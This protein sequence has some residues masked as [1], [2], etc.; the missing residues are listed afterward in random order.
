[1]DG[2]VS[3]HLPNG[4]DASLPLV[5]DP[6]VVFATFTGATS[7]NWGATATYDKSGNFYGGGTSAAAGFPV[8]LGAFQT[9]HGGGTT[10][11]VPGDMAFIKFD[12]TGATKIWA[13]YLGGNGLDQPH[14]MIVDSADNLI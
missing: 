2:V 5:I 10:L 8:S 7:D 3:Y 6:V 13:S 1:R 12:P 14:S 11:G 9:T 4:Y